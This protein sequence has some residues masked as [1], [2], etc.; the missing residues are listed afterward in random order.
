[1][2]ANGSRR[3][4][5]DWAVRTPRSSGP[6]A[7]ADAARAHLEALT[8]RLRGGDAASLPEVLRGRGGRRLDEGLEVEPRLRGA[9]TAVLGDALTATS[10]P[11]DAGV[12]L[13]PGGAVGTFVVEGRVAGRGP[14]AG[15]LRALGT[16]RGG[17]WRAARRRRAARSHGARHPVAGPER[18]GA[19]PRGSAR[20][21][22]TLLP[23]WRI[24]TP[25][26]ALVTDEGVVRLGTSQDAL[27]VRAR[28]AEAERAIRDGEARAADAE[29]ERAKAAAA[30]DT[31][32]GRP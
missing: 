15:Y 8:R 1:M 22:R 9:V 7:E 11:A 32:R 27:E 2:P 26:G 20:A 14:P 17:R 21:G 23:G 19:G 29:R 24:A 16:H 31:A 3:R 30:L 10:V 12:A 13:S 5:S 18:V 25:E 6:A 4:R 28:A